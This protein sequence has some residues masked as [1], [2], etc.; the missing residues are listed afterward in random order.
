VAT[1]AADLTAR[2][3]II[4]AVWTLITHFVVMRISSSPGQYNLYIPL[5]PVAMGVVILISVMFDLR[6]FHIWNAR[7]GDLPK[8]GENS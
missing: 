7:I 8:S 3:C 6:R 5:I 4:T 1:I 2:V